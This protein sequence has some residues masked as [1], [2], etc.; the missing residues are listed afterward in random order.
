MLERFKIRP[1]VWPKEVASALIP[2]LQRYSWL[3]PAW[4]TEVNVDYENVNSK[5]PTAVAKT[6]VNYEYRNAFITFYALWLNDDEYSRRMNLVHELCHVM[7]GPLADYM[8]DVIRDTL[9]DEVLK[10]IV[11]RELENRIESVTQDMATSILEMEDRLA[12]IL[13]DKELEKALRKPWRVTAGQPGQRI[14]QHAQGRMKKGLKR[15]TAIA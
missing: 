10:N 13:T 8:A 12:R 9:Y 15:P 11:L 2:L 3:I 7:N 14:V 4:C 1:D 6:Y 5:S